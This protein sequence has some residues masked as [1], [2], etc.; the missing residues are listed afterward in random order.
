[1]Q[2][3]IWEQR[4]SLTIKRFH[5]RTLYLLVLEAI[6]RNRFVLIHARMPSP[7]HTR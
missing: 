1:M 3:S 7:S 5:W 2:K 4:E 6:E